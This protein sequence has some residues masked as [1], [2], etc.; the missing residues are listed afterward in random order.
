MGQRLKSSTGDVWY[1]LAESFLYAGMSALLLLLTAQFHQYWFLSLVALTPFLYKIT[2]SSLSESVR[3][4]FLLG[5][6]FLTVCLSNQLLADFWPTLLKL[7]CGVFLFILFSWAL[8][9]AR[10]SFG[11]NPIITALIWVG[12]ELAVIRL[13]FA[14]GLFGEAELSN[15]HLNSLMLLFG[16]VIVSFIIVLLNSLIVLTVEKIISLG[17]ARETTSCDDTRIR[18]PYSSPALFTQRCYLVPEV[19]GPPS[20]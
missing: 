15:P 2:R 8:C 18:D 7:L 5:L 13:G 1:R 3:L 6:T 12:F 11:F 17:K 4:G 9:R 20:I 14:R 16:F 10:M 19:R